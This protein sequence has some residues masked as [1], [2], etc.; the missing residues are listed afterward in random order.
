M[1]LSKIENLLQKYE[2]AETTIA[3]ENELKLYFSSNDVA[4][5]LQHYCLVFDYYVQAKQDQFSASIPLQS[6]HKKIKWIG[7]AATVSLLSGLVFFI[8]LS[9]PNTAVVTDLGTFNNP[10]T[11]LKETQ[12]ALALLSNHV[13]A[14]IESVNY[15]TEY[16]KSKERI[17]N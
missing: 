2:D 6:K 3:E 10:E 16:Q 12:K 14:G 4:Q 15:V 7:I 17:F 13:N 1:E 5:H 9:K 8:T 11:A